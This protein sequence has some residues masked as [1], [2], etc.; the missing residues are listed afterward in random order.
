MVRRPAFTLVELLVVVAIISVLIGLLLPAVQAAR[1]AARRAQCASNMRQIGL[2]IHQFAE[3]HGGRFPLVAHERARSESW[4]YTLAP[5]LE[6]VDEIRLCPDDLERRELETGRVTSYAMNGYLRPADI[7]PFGAEPGF[8]AKLYDLLETQRTIV[9]FEAGG[10][11]VDGNFDHV[12]SP[13]WFDAY[14]LKRNAPPN[15]AV[16]N[17]VKAEV[18]VARH[19]GGVANYLFADGH[20]EPIAAEQIAEWC[21]TEFN[22]AIPPQ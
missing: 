7:G 15:H 22:F 17:A 12:E 16:W 18:A 2:A 8:V 10:A 9:V 6:S 5:Y 1:A 3:A 13:D 14:N 11:K 20:V 21:D 19:G 4:I